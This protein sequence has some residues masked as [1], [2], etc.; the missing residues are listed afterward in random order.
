MLPIFFKIILYCFLTC[1]NFHTDDN[2]DLRRY[3][4]GFLSK[5]FKVLAFVDGVSLLEYALRHPPDLIITDMQMPRIDDG[6]RLISA[7]RSNSATALIPII[8][9]SANAAPEARIEALL[10]ADDYLTKPFSSKELL[11]RVNIHLQL[12]K[13]RMEL[14]RRVEERTRALIASEMR[15]RA[16]ADRYSTLSVLSPVGIFLV[17]HEGL[18][19]CTLVSVCESRQSR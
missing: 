17:D 1:A 9:L 11:A 16:L 10:Q 14:E 19:T 7:L 5:S 18:I 4:S 6:H 3:I 2:H 12:G 8:C 13:M 15:Y